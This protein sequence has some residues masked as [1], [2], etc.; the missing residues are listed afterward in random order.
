MLHEQLERFGLEAIHLN[1]YKNTLAGFE[2]VPTAACLV[3]ALGRGRRRSRRSRRRS[4]RF[5]VLQRSQGKEVKASGTPAQRNRDRKRNKHRHRHARG[6]FRC[7]N[8]LRYS[9]KRSIVLL[10]PP[11]G[12]EECITLELKEP[13]RV[14]E[15]RYCIISTV[16]VLGVF[17]HNGIAA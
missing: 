12:V 2:E 4:E 7:K 8:A 6:T 10:R 3:R 11:Q 1:Y 5:Q 16:E 14:V 13:L 9:W 17:A 15:L